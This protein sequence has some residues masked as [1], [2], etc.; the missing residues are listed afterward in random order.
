MKRYSSEQVLYHYNTFVNDN[1][2]NPY[3]PMSI[4]RVEEYELMQV[5]VSSLLLNPYKSSKR[6]LKA[7]CDLDLS[8]SPPIILGKSYKSGYEVLD[9]N[10]RGLAHQYLGEELIWAYVPVEKPMKLYH[11]SPELDIIPE[12][13]PRIPSEIAV[14]EDIMEE[15]ICVSNTIEGC[16]SS[17]PWGGV[18]LEYTLYNEELEENRKLFRVYEFDTSY[19]YSGHIMTPKELWMYDYVSDA[20]Y[21][22]EHWIL[23]NEP[24]SSTYLIEVTDWEESCQ[25]LL[26]YKDELAI[27]N[28]EDYEYVWDG[29]CT[30]VIESLTYRRI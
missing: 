21:K 4:E 7:Y 27:A 2:E 24:Y 5:S 22:G 9:G 19:I 18:A 10:H 29:S 30:T 23:E 20:I 12:F 6:K 28:G 26:S 16:F 14:G 15:R 13:V 3:I 25:D 17:A 11:V 1:I 8:T